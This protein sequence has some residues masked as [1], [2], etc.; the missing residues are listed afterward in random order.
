MSSSS[1]AANEPSPGKTYRL[2]A[3]FALAILGLLSLAIY[4]LS[5]ME[6]TPWT[7]PLAELRIQDTFRKNLPQFEYTDGEKRLTPQN[8]EGKWTLLSFWSYSC[9][10]CLEEMPSLN[11][12]SLGW[13][14]PE[15]EVITVNV[16]EEKTENFEQAKAFLQ[17]QEIV[18]PTLF[19]KNKVLTKA[20]AVEVFPKHF[21]VNPKA[22]VVWEG[23]GS[24]QWDSAESRDQLL[25]LIERQT[26]ETNPDPG[27]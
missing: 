4:S 15:L 20:F 1:S 21:L 13:S 16:D 6:A 22:E 23:Q 12:L 17:D 19:D 27:E 5:R 24:Y 3:L 9:P 25:K 7:S 10:P 26:P 2:M 14:G 8:F 18:L 11:Q